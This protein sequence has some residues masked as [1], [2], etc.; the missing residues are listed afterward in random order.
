M[1]TRRLVAVATALSMVAACGAE[2]SFG[3]RP[4]ARPPSTASERCY[5]ER[6]LEVTTGTAEVTW[7]EPAGGNWERHVREY[8]KGLVFYRGGRRLTP[9]AALRVFGDRELSAVYERK[10]DRLGGRYRSSRNAA[11]FGFIGFFGGAAGL[12]A[13]GAIDNDGITTERD[14]QI[15]GGLALT[16]LISVPFLMYGTL[17]MNK[18]RQKWDAYRELMF[19]AGIIDRLQYRIDELNAGVARECGHVAR[20]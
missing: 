5:Q 10:L 12:L 3:T 18:R 13:Y 1:R 11:T 7:S 20:R 8:Q 6:S 2:I 16:A 14:K 15:L 17:T 9:S 19:E 4:L